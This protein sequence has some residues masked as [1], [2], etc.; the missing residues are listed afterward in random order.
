M[1]V[2]FLPRRSSGNFLI[3]PTT[4]P[5]AFGVPAPSP[6]AIGFNGGTYFT[7]A[8][9]AAG[10]TTLTVQNVPTVT[11][12]SPTGGLTT[13]GAV[14]TVSGTNFLT[15]G[16]TNTVT[17]G[18]VAATTVTNGTATS[19]TATAPAGAAGTVNVVV[20]NTNG[21]SVNNGTLDDFTYNVPIPTLTEWAMILLG[22]ML[23][24]LGALFVHSRGLTPRRA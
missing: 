22:M 6:P 18:G 21:T 16:G 12:L 20:S 5:N 11:L 15:G 14:V 2:P 19:L 24:G 8:Y 7:N 3:T 17:F 13:G 23:A 4:A 9:A 10:T 1:R